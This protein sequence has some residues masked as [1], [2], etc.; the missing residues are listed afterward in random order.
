MVNVFSLSVVYLVVC[1][2]LACLLLWAGDGV[3]CG[4]AVP[5]KDEVERILGVVAAARVVCFVPVDVVRVLVDA[6]D[7][8]G[9]VLVAHGDGGS[10]GE[11]FFNVVAV[12]G[13]LFAGFFVNENGVLIS[14]EVVVGADPH[15]PRPRERGA[16]GRGVRCFGEGDSRTCGGVCPH[17]AVVADG[18][19]RVFCVVG[20]R[21]DVGRVGFYVDAHEH[22]V[23]D[24]A[25]LL[26][27]NDVC[28][29]EDAVDPHGCVEKDG[30]LHERAFFP[31]WCLSLMPTV[32]HG[33]A[34]RVYMCRDSDCAVCD[35]VCFGY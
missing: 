30:C 7:G 26:E 12:D 9:R 22:G 23:V 32:Y 13:H 31:W 6:G 21:R 17:G 15:L 10:Y 18:D 1:A 33:N 8:D 4:C 35:G 3:A 34:R 14:V 20:G 28:A 5:L 19:G 29:L 11:V 24:V 2:L 16:L 27:P 25:V